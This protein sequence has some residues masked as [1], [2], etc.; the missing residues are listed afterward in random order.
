MNVLRR[1]RL[2]VPMSAS[3]PLP[4]GIGA[5]WPSFPPP[6]TY[7]FGTYS[8]NLHL[9]FIAWLLVLRWDWHRLERGFTLVINRSPGRHR[10]PGVNSRSFCR[11]TARVSLGH[12]VAGNVVKDSEVENVWGCRSVQGVSWAGAS[13]VAQTSAPA[14]LVSRASAPIDGGSAIAASPVPTSDP[15][16]PRRRLP[17]R[18]DLIFLPLPSIAKA[19]RAASASALTVSLFISF[20]AL[21]KEASLRTRRERVVGEEP[22]R[23]LAPA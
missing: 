7:T 23:I 21:L 20:A 10:S 4:L 13:L 9:P 3:L 18:F 11:A 17:P 22:G 6:L 1:L 19:S 8:G 16:L 14:C 15:R 2:L 12:M 5:V